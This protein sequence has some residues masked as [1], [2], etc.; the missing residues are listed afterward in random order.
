MIGEFTGVLTIIMLSFTYALMTTYMFTIALNLCS[1]TITWSCSCSRSALALGR[2]RAPALLSLSIVLPLC[3][4]S[5]SCSSPPPVVLFFPLG[6][7]LLD[8]VL[9]SVLLLLL[10]FLASGGRDCVRPEALCR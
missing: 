9:L 3:S 1:S 8:F 4:R 2:A 6:R 10:S 7:A 5:R